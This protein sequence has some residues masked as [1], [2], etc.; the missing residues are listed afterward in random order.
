MEPFNL[1]KLKEQELKSM[2]VKEQEQIQIKFYKVSD[3][4]GLHK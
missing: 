1:R 4:V 2:I 3:F